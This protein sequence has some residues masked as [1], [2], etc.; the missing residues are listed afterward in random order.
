[1]STN[2]L[3]DNPTKITFK[4]KFIVLCIEFQ[5]VLIDL[6]I[7]Q[8]VLKHTVN[9]GMN[10]LKYFLSPTNL[11][12]SSFVQLEPIAQSDCLVGLDNLKN[13]NFISYQVQSN[14]IQTFNNDWLVVESF[15]MNENLLVAYDKTEKQ[16]VGF[17]LR[18]S[19]KA[20]EEPFS[21]V[22]FKLSLNRNIS[23][24]NHYGISLDCKS[25]F[26]V[27][28]NKKLKSYR[29]SNMTLTGEMMLYSSVGAIVCSDRFVCM[30]SE[31]RRVISYMVCDPEDPRSKM[32][33]KKLASR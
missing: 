4:S 6:A 24:L 16:L 19:L 25:L 32:N 5:L 9:N 11:T 28:E 21:K 10:S 23:V 15:K 17:D 27:E 29:L 33:I 18:N 31:D 30:T 20:K 13:L 3:L 2:N 26:T 1:V 14:S 12:S 8:V 22:L 7:G